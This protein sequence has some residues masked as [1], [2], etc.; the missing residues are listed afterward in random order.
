[1][2]YAYGTALANTTAPVWLSPQG[3]TVRPA[4]ADT[5]APGLFDEAMTRP[6]GEVVVLADP[7]VKETPWAGIMVSILSGQWAAFFSDVPTTPPAELLELAKVQYQGLFH[8]WVRSNPAL[9]I[10]LPPPPPDEYRHQAVL[11]VTPDALLLLL[12]GTRPVRFTS[13]LPPDATLA[14][15]GFDLQVNAFVLIVEHPSFPPA[16]YGTVLPILP[17][18]AVEQLGP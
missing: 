12:Q 2:L 15:A 14:T 18:V 13:H 17:P 6:V 9:H 5:L 8:T 1:M 10:A 16:P 3:H 7:S 11:Y 4:W